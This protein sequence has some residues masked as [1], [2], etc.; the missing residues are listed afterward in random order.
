MSTIYF[1]DPSLSHPSLGT[2]IGRDTDGTYQFLGVQY[3]T[4]QHRFAESQLKTEYKSPVDARNHG[5][6]PRAIFVL[7]PRMAK[8]CL[9]ALYS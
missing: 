6:D 7:F 1:T 8:R 3:A 5:Y 4:L 9:E 2:L